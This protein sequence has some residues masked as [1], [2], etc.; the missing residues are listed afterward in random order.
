MERTPTVFLIDDDTDDQEIF[1][2]AMKQADDSVNCIFA[3]DGIH[4]LEKIKAEEN[5]VPDFI[6][7]DINMPRMNGQQCLK[8]IKKIERLK[9]TPVFMYSTSADPS[10]IEE[11]IQLGA[12]EFIVKPADVNDLTKILSRIVK[13]NV[14]ALILL[15]CFFG[16]VPFKS[17]GQ[18]DT[19]RVKELKKLSVEDLMNIVVTSV[20]KSPEKLSEVASAIQVVT[21]EEIKRSGTLRLPGALRLATNMQVY[22]SG[23][24]NT[25]ISSRG[26]NG[27]PIDNTSF[28]NKLLVLIDGRTVYTPLLGGVYWDVQNVLLEDVKQIEV[29]SGPGGS[30][31]G[32]NAVNGIVNII[33][34]SAK[35]TQG[36]YASGASGGSLKDFGA[37]R[38]GSHIDTTFFYR[39]YAQRYDI[40]SSTLANGIDAKDAWG[41]SQGGFRMDYIP[42]TKSTFTLQGDLYDGKENDSASTLV[43]GQNMVARWTYRFSD[44]SGVTVQSYFDRTYRNVPGSFID[45]FNTFDI[46][47]QHN[48]SIGSRNKIVW[49]IGYRTADNSFNSA[50]NTIQPNRKTLLL[51]SGFVQDQIAIIPERI[52]LTIGT[53]VLHNDYTGLEF[54][55]TVRL[56]YFINDKNTLW[57]SVSRAV[58]TPSRL[59]ADI[60]SPVSFKSENLLAYELGY[61]M[62]PID[63]VSFSIATYYNQYTRL[64]S[65]DTN[66]ASPSEFYFGNNLKAN[67]SG[68]EVSA[69]AI[70]TS[71]WKVRGG[72]NW[73]HQKFATTSTLTYPQSY[74][75]EAIDP[76]NQF[77]IQ[78]M[79][80]VAKHFQIDCIVRYVDVVPA[81]LTL[82]SIPSYLTF[83][84]RLAYNY[85]WVTVSVVGTNLAQKYHGSSGSIQIPRSIY[86]RI[87][88]SF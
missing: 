52:D 65:L 33:S 7:I 3:D 74:L 64:R 14:L 29:I 83:D 76:Q 17:F 10:V 79:I 57:A 6:F 78:S 87:T 86:G 13:Q 30:L 60:A 69:E 82:P 12:A 49:G 66:P 44:K 46:D 61:R 2:Y 77:L 73:L 22:S 70:V 42:S 26:F 72:Y 23:A 45:E 9:N 59:D 19:L 11:N 43:N 15:I 63:N 54:Q 18:T 85:K 39:V 40:N 34:K 81:A 58:R 56:A 31:W 24:H 67:T 51:Y 36:I 68:I 71:W 55:P 38:Y 48:F 5:F 21:G 75:L 47:M 80:E 4:A 84:L 8:E 1:S 62:Q 25:R 16:I 32:A 53:K 50:A 28:G 35:E 27:Y 41:I 20:S 88:V 37:L